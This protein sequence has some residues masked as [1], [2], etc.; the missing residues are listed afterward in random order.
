MRILI[1]L[2]IALAAV[3][4]AGCAASSAGASATSEPDQLQARLD[5][6]NR[7]SEDLDIYI[8]RAGQRAR[9]GMAPAGKTTG[10]SLSK[11]LM[12]GGSS[13]FE[14]VRIGGA[15]APVAPVR[16]E[17]LTVRPGEV[18]TLDVPPQ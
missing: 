9:L 12:T 16:T 2:L 15:G 10:F 5:V 18:I 17:L 11:S 14:A 7:T 4:S 3:S 6:Q 13:Q 1:P 8:I